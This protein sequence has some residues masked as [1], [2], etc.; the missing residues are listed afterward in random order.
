ML[1]KGCTLVISLFKVD[2]QAS[3][4]WIMAHRKSAEAVVQGGNR[5]RRA[6]YNQFIL[7]V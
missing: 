6:Y 2:A 1:C 4:G 5:Q 3:S 7:S